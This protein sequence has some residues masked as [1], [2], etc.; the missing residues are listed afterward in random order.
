MAGVYNG[1]VTISIDAA[2]TVSVSPDTLQTYP[3]KHIVY[4]IQNLHNQ[5]HKVGVAPSDFKKKKKDDPDDPIKF[6]FKHSDG[7]DPGDIGAITLHVKDKD[8]FGKPGTYSYKYTV[9]AS[10]LPDLDPSIDI[11]N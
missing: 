4:V 11:N 6:T 9:T 2:G 10:G 1:V 5:S 3:D 8:H 7:V